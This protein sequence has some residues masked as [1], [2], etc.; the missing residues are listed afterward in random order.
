MKRR[1]FLTGI[2]A[3][4]A[5]IATGGLWTPSAARGQNPPNGCPPAPVNG[6][7]FRR[8]QDTRPVVQRKSVSSLSSSQIAQLRLAFSKLRSLP[9]TDNRRWVIQADM[10]A[11][12]CQACNNGT[13]QSVHGSWAFFPWHR[14]FLYYYERILGSLVGDI[15]NFRLPYWDWENQRSLPWF[16]R[17]PA[18]SSNSLYDVSRYAPI[19]GGAALPTNDGSA[20]RIAVLDGITDFATFGGTASRGGACESNP[21]DP[22]HDDIGL[23]ASPFH[24]MGHLGWAARDPIFY[25]HHGNIDKIWSNWNALSATS[26]TPA[27]RNPTDPAFLSERWNFYD[28]H[29]RVVS[30]SA[31][32]VLN[33]SSYLR[34]SYP[35]PTTAH[36]STA[37]SSSVAVPTAPVVNMYEA[38]LNYSGNGLRP[39]P[40]L[41]LSYTVKTSLVQAV[42]EQS[43]VA[44]V[45]RGVPVPENATGVF[46]IMSVR[47]SSMKHLGTLAVV[48]DAMRMGTLPKTVVLDATDAIDDLVD[49]SN[50]ARITVVPREGNANFTLRAEEMDV[51]VISRQ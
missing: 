4:G 26:P 40:A 6:T 8:G 48:A 20:A 9:S 3:G 32:D 33:Y 41:D 13:H 22:I 31:A 29:G 23:H 24:D 28:E 17:S 42:R 51:R 37:L 30:I 39:G 36:R 47:G 19:N 11:M 25:A 2:A 12:F 14:A 49:A 18:G 38:R 21:H 27:Y 5:A 10:H 15:N 50:P 34:Y 44:I 45:L 7:P 1:Q 43:S 16:Y 35:T 46:D